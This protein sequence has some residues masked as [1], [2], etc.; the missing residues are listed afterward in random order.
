MSDSVR[1]G[2][3]ACCLLVASDVLALAKGGRSE[4]P[5]DVEWVLVAGLLL[6]ILNLYFIGK[7][8][9][10]GRGRQAAIGALLSGLAMLEAFAPAWI[11]FLKA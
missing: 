10:R 4:V 9:L 5:L 7:D 11:G 6:P 3:I 8:A 2:A 1:C